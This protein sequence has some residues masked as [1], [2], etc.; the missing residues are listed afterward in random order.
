[1][2]TASPTALVTGAASGIGRALAQLLHDRGARVHAIDVD[3][4]GLDQV[5]AGFGERRSGMSEEGDDPLDV[6]A[7]ALRA[8][9][10]E[11]FSVMPPG[12]ADAVVERAT[13]LV[14]GSQP[15]IPSYANQPEP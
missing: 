8:V 3:R 2:T 6:A 10:N 4:A 15:E 11:T 9:D 1:M 7:E 14:D 12:W 5:A 13:R